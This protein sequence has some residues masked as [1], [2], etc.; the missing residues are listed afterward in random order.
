MNTALIVIDVQN[1]YFPGGKMELSGS[2]AAADALAWLLGHCR[3]SGMPVVHVRHVSVRPGATFFLPDT[4]GAEIHRSVQPQE[5]EPVFLKHFPNSFRGTAL[6]GYLKE[7]GITRL[8]VAGMMTHLCVDTTVRAA[9]D[10]GYRCILAGDSCAT[11]DLS[12]DGRRVA[13]AQVQDAFL[14]SLQGTFSSVMNTD[15]VIELLQGE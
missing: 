3:G 5:G 10:L 2:E 7:R 4:E 13:A 8:V 12:I 1:D 6:D 14:A 11:R 15:R 9:F